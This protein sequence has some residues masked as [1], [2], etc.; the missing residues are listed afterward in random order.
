MPPEMERQTCLQGTPRPWVLKG[1]RPVSLGRRYQGTL[2]PEEVAVCS[3]QHLDTVPTRAEQ[4]LIPHCFLRKREGLIPLL[5]TEPLL[6]MDLRPTPTRR[7][8]HGVSWG[9]LFR[10]PLT[11]HSHPQ[12]CQA[13]PTS[14]TISQ[15]SWENLKYSMS[16]PP[17]VNLFFDNNPTFW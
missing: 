10:A 13:T 4:Q 1:L 8:A 6:H 17:P 11:H 12:Q 9:T 14:L 16:F 7:A 15:K 3:A 2:V 5:P